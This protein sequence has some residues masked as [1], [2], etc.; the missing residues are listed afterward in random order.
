LKQ[1]WHYLSDKFISGLHLHGGGT[2]SL[3]HIRLYGSTCLNASYIASAIDI[4]LGSFR[5][6][7]NVPKNPQTASEMIRSVARLMWHVRDGDRI[8]LRDRG[9]IVRPET[10]KVPAYQ[11]EYDDLL[12]QLKALIRG[13]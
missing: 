13:G 9:L 4:V 6:C 3:D 1:Q 5:Y 12:E 8:L 2:A 7:V 11:K 10:V